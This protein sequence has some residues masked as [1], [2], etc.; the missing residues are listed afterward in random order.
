[1]K[2]PW[3]P[4]NAVKHFMWKKKDSCPNIFLLKREE[5]MNVKQKF[6]VSMVNINAM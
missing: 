3:I 4:Y 1:M 2:Q 6:V 5:F